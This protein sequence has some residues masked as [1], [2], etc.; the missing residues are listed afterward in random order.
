MQINDLNNGLFD[1]APSALETFL[2]W[3][4]DHYFLGTFLVLMLCYVLVLPFKLV[5][6]FIRSRNIKN[7]GWPPSHLDADGAFKD[8]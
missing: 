1:H 2:V 6:R 8:K 5:N 7:Q 3:Y 4:G